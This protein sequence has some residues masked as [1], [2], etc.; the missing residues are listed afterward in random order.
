MSL[1]K[2]RAQKRMSKCKE[3]G[4]HSRPGEE[5]HLSTCS[6][7][8]GW[9]ERQDWTP[10][11]FEAFRNEISLCDSCHCM[12]YTIKGKCGKCRAKK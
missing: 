11:K 2:N 12:T 8:G 1:M 4:A 10:E 9:I 5:V 3:C 7:G 6:M